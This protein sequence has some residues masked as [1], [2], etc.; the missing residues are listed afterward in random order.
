MADIGI[1][2]CRLVCISFRS[3]RIFVYFLWPFGT[4]FPFGYFASRKIWQPWHRR[5]QLKSFIGLILSRY[6]REKKVGLFIFASGCQIQR[7]ATKTKTTFRRSPRHTRKQG[8]PAARAT[9]LGEL[10]PIGR[11]FSLGSLF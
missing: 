10:S 9:R 4:F 6:L 11:L 1:F 2:Y 5:M 8:R 3:F 7:A